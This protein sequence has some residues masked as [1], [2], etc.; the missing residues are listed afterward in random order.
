LAKHRIIADPAALTL[1]GGGACTPADLETALSLAP[2][3]VAADSGADFALSQGV[4]PKAVFG[5]MDSISDGARAQIPQDRIFHIAE[6]DSTDFDKALRHMRTPLVIAVG[7]LG[8]QIDHELAA[9]NTVARRSDERIVLLGGEDVAF[10][11]PPEI[12]LALDARTRV[13]LFP[14]GPVTGQSEGLVWP[15]DGI[16][17]APSN[18]I[19][20]SNRSK[21]AITL[22][23]DAPGMLCI[24]PRCFIAPVVSS[25]LALPEH[26]L[27]PARAG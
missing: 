1:V 22:R 7:F 15:I 12:S 26:A 2:H 14:M 27:W 17:F 6:Q 4:Q 18:R 21:G 20:T 19:G 9:L 8:G 23:M 10:H 11:C 5:D 24:V 3:C 25:L 13:S 16:A